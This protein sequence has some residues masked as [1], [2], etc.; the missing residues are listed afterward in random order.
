MKS[1]KFAERMLLLKNP[2]KNYTVHLG[3]GDEN[4]EKAW[5]LKKQLIFHESIVV[6]VSC[7][8][9]GVRKWD[10]EKYIWIILDLIW[11]E[12]HYILILHPVTLD[13]R[14]VSCECRNFAAFETLL[15]WKGGFMNPCQI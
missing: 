15:R 1:G 4:A 12:G 8:Y 6:T 7:S 9:S 14:F 3:K 10:S 11:D 2:L 13:D 5:F